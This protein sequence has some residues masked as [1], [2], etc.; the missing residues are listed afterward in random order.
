[1]K[2][3]FKNVK[4]V[5][6]GKVLYNKELI[7]SKGKIQSIVD[8][9]STVDK[10][11]GGYRLVDGGGMFLS[12]GF[13]D[14]H[15]HGSLG[16]DI[17]DRSKEALNGIGSYH[18]KNGVTS[19]LGTVIT[20]SYENMK[21][22][23]ENIVDYEN[24]DTSKIL[25]I[26]LE[27]PFFNREKKG[28]QNIDFIKDPDLGWIKNLLNISSGKLKMVSLAPELDRAREVIKYLKS[29]GVKVAIGHSS[30][31]YE[32]AKAAIDHGASIAT[33]LFN[34][35]RDFHHREPGLVGASLVDGRIYCELIYD[36]FHMHDA[37]VEIALK[38]KGYGKVILVSDAMRA[39]GLTDG[40]YEL[41]GQAVWV[42]DGGA[43]LESGTIAGS[44]LSLREAV[45][46]MV[47]YLGVP[48]NEAV[49]MA[50]LNPAQALGFH[51]DI[52]SI[53]EGK[54][55]D[56]ILFD[57]DINIKKVFSGGRELWKKS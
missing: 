56:L 23:I 5:L 9:V 30:A 14:I 36:R 19:Y 41:G 52:G 33:H 35:M 43:R 39:A 16:F 21:A 34:G 8:E 6:P 3:K 50:S 45:Y 44:T 48:I 29:K 31:S 18:I 37:A 22:A 15:N 49:R 47:K 53:E 24:K 4:I 55:A 11:E 1:M 12:P 40:E 57:K 13:I 25:A 26:H 28:A 10:L 7:V 2:L 32:E 38:M 42:K 17:M 54:R 20:S 46:N 51:K 27:G